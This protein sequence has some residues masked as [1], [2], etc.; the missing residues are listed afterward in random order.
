MPCPSHFKSC[1]SN[2]LSLRAGAMKGWSSS[3]KNSNITDTSWIHNFHAKGGC[4]WS[5]TS[6]VFITNPKSQ[7]VALCILGYAW[8]HRSKHVHY[9]PVTVQGRAK[10][11]YTSYESFGVQSC[12]MQ[13]SSTGM[14]TMQHY[15]EWHID[16]AAKYPHAFT[17]NCEEDMCSMCSSYSTYVLLSVWLQIYV[18]EGRLLSLFHE[19]LA[20]RH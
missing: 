19:G 15:C 6:F 14:A 12:I 13:G 10:P 16:R 18:L 1:N 7:V 2:R 20:Q 17:Y 3:G 11:S 9:V 8:C 4:H 5:I